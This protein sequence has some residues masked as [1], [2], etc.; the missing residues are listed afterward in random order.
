M[1][2]TTTDYYVPN[3][4]FYDSEQ[5]TWV[6]FDPATRRVIF[7]LDTL[8]LAALGDLAYISLPDDG[9]PVK[10]GEPIGALEAAKMTGDLIAPVSGTLVS[11]NYTILRDPSLVNN[12]PYNDGWLAVIDPSD[13]EGESGLLISGEV[14]PAWVAAEIERYRSKGWITA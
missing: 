11:V 4:R 3:D 8:N 5:H 13:W 6:Q 9:A 1:M 7:G 12:D 14:L 2:K 10:R